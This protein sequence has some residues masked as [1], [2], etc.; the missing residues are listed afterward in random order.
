MA[1]ASREIV[2]EQAE[3]WPESSDYNAKLWCVLKFCRASG[4]ACWTSLAG[5]S[6]VAVSAERRV[7][8]PE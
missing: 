2:E 1:P 7:A 4:E 5:E 8:D 3:E 6:P